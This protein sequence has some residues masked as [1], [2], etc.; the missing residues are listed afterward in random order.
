DL[1][2]PF[3][4]PIRAR[5]KSMKKG[6]SVLLAVCGL[7]VLAGC[8]HERFSW[9]FGPKALKFSQWRPLARDQKLARRILALDPLNITAED[10]KITLSR[11]PAPW[12]MPISPAFPG[13]IIFKDL[14]KFLID[15]GYPPG[16]IGDPRSD[17]FTLSYR[18]PSE[19]IAGLAA[20]TYERDGMS[21][22][23][24]GWS[25]GGITAV[26]AL[27]D[28]S[29]PVNKEE[30]KVVSGLTGE[31]EDRG[32]ILDPYTGEKRPIAGVKISFAGVLM[33]G[34]LSRLF[35]LF[36]WGERP[37]LHAVPDSVNELVAF[38]APA[39]PLGTDLLSGDTARSNEFKPMGTAK[40]RT[41]IADPSYGH[42][43]VIH[44]YLLTQNKKGRGW[45]AAYRPEGGWGLRDFRK[46]ARYALDWGKRNLWCGEL[47]Y[48]VKKHWAL[49]AQRVAR[50][51]LSGRAEP[52]GRLLS[53]RPGP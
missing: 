50:A 30:L 5:G 25:A 47:W 49:E 51:V 43:N 33:A 9:D 40:V 2:H 20:W 17:D 28:L 23:L 7:L 46:T 29:N 19:T 36:R 3:T 1:K 10:V 21:P 53:A 48:A 42:V 45:A 44:C 39:D 14:F 37:P 32:W 6:A 22:M 52:A 4:C 12:I 26:S 15:M 41:I 27:H 31:A 8:A 38:H 11:G 16:R 18:E 24:V 34:G 35:H 13:P